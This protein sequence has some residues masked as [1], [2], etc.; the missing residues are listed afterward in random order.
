M[1][2][3]L[4]ALSRLSGIPIFEVKI[5]CILKIIKTVVKVYNII[6]NVI[7]STGKS[8]QVNG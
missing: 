1:I 2:L 4:A 5:Y 6:D 7:L 8:S 3:E